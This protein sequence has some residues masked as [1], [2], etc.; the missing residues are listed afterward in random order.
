M[1]TTTALLLEKILGKMKREKMLRQLDKSIS[2]DRNGEVLALKLRTHCFLSLFFSK[3]K[4]PSLSP[5]FCKVRF[6][7][8]V[9]FYFIPLS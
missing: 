9:D 6:F 7:F 4:Y 8:Q 2:F 5:L 3:F 1:V